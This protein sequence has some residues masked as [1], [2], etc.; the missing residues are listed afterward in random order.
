MIKEC[1]KNVKEKSPL[2]HCITN[3]VTVNDC[4]NV[5]LAA[6]GSPIMS[7]EVLEVSEITSICASL[8]I[9]IGT[10]NEN[11]IKSM[12]IASKTANKLGKKI[13]LDPVGVG[14][15]SLR[16]EIAFKLI[17]EIKFSVIKGNV[18]EIKFL[19]TGSGDTQGVD[20]SIY[21]KVTSENIINVIEFAKS[22]SKKTRAVIVI[23]GEIDI[24]CDEKKAY[25][26]RNGHC[27]M[28]KI[29]GSG[30][31]LSAIIGAYVGANEST[32]ESCVSAVSLMGLSG[33]LAYKKL[34]ETCGGNSTY[35][36]LLI[37]FISKIDEKTLEEGAKIECV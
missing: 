32:I 7:D 11:T 22:F 26:I 37:D 12:F 6:G 34:S 18:S 31:M 10:L 28:S 36:N 19:A 9:N 16:N 13:V 20:A 14:A 27:M 30:C 4:A 21:D 25:V 1:L 5:I 3:Y 29:T 35:R 23:T 24:V 17:E 33:E 8:V 2:V 15:S